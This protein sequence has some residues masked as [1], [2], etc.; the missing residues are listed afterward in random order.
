MKVAIRTSAVLMLILAAIAV[1]VYGYLR[2]QLQR[3]PNDPAQIE[4]YFSRPA[5]TPDFVSRKRAPCNSEYPLNKAWFGALHIH[6][7]ASYDAGAFGV[8]NTADTAY[9]FASG[10]TAEY[11][12]QDDP[13]GS[14]VPRI[15]LP[16]RLD[17]AAVT[18]HAG[19]LGEQRVCLDP[20]RAGYNALVC[21]VYRG[22]VR[23]PMD[24]MM[25]P[26]VRLASQ[27]IFGGNRSARV[28]GPGGGDCRDEAR[29]AWQE[30]QLAAEQWYDRSS[31]CTF[32]TFSAYEYTLAEEASNL[33]R[34]V[35]FATGSVPPAVASAHDLQQPEQLW[36]WLADSCKNRGENCDVLTIP[37][38]SN[39]SSGRMWYPYSYREDL[40]RE[41]QVRYARLRAELEPLAEVMQ[42]KGDSECRNGLTTVTGSA[43]ELCNFEKLRAPAEPFEDCGEAFGSGN[44]R[45][46]GCISRFSYVR[47][48]LTA[49]LAEQQALGINPFKLGILAATDNHNGTPTAELENGYLGAS[50]L[51]RDAQRRLLGAVEVPGGIAKGSPVRYNPGGLAGVWA[52]E[53]SRPALFEA[54]QRR[55]TFG[56]SGPRIQPRFFGGWNID[57]SLCE[58]PRLAEKAYASAV[59]MGSD[60]PTRPAGS[61]APQFIASAPQDPQG[62]LL[63]HIQVIKGW[64]DKAGRTHQAV[65]NIAGDP[66][67][68]ASVDTRT[69]EVSGQGYSQLCAVW[70]DPDFKPDQ[71]AVYYSRV[72]ENPSCRWSTYDCNALPETERPASC[73]DPAV[74]QTI[75]ERAWTSPIWYHPD[76]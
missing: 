53:N 20:R 39:W 46:V 24:D 36:Q 5:S 19:K 22:D 10:Q 43:D 47:Y 61:G 58:S 4:A 25:Q 16:R 6:T 44:M 51:D 40:S 45:L 64:I 30:N 41:Q 49:G 57:K 28:C 34:N 31:D 23:L 37:H 35:I 13:P 71:A 18:D 54:M 32:T 1:C 69:C 12:L 42:V 73:S 14:K 63:Q 56:T 2:F 21:K 9:A 62:N 29:D 52:R 59:P 33:H 67:N 55:E 26:L 38:N 66:T 8:T 3:R 7:A 50:G 75:Q 27:A 15:T 70:Q 72:L 11:R 76:S 74:P 68:G 65:F 48:A 60:L 17:F